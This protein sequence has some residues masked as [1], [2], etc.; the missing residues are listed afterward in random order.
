MVDRCRR[1]EHYHV[2]R[3]STFQ[4]IFLRYCFLQNYPC[5]KVASLRAI[6]RCSSRLLHLWNLYDLDRRWK[7]RS[8]LALGEMFFVLDCVQA[9]LID[10][11]VVVE[12]VAMMV[13]QVV[14]VG[15]SQSSASGDES[16]CALV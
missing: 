1:M 12:D 5:P 11:L 15:S 9:R 6:H 7:N 8:G 4:T 3:C 16:P 10:E 13:P 2:L 14:P